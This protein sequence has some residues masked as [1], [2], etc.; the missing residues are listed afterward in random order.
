MIVEIRRD[1]LPACLDIL[2]RSYEPVALRFGLT[3][4]NCPHRGGAD[5]PLEVLAGEFDAGAMLYGYFVEGGLVGL[6]SMSKRDE[7]L[8]INDIVVLPEC[9]GRGIGGALLDFVKRAAKDQGADKVMLGMID[10]NTA[11]K[12]WYEVHGFTTVGMRNFEGAPFTVGY[13]EWDGERQG[14]PRGPV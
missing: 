8:K 13:M 9:Q 5:L 11:L 3:R 1:Q 12:R 2:H 4:E 7:A 10:D 14:A 6:V